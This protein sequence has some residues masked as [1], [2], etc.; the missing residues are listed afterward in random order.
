MPRRDG[1]RHDNAVVRTNESGELVLGLGEPAGG[2][3]GP[4][5][6]ELECLA[7][8]ERVELR[9]TVERDRRESFFFPNG[10]DFVRLPDEVRRSVD[11]RDEILGR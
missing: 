1:E 8:R 11:R 10:T 4:L 3:R 6:L 7:S 2:D 5:C 9:R